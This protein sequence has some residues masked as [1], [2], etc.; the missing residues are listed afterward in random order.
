MAK[1]MPRVSGAQTGGKRG[2]GVPTNT[3]GGA[4]ERR[5]MLFLG[6]FMVAAAFTID[7]V[8]LVVTAGLVWI[9]IVGAIASFVIDMGISVMATCL[10]A[11][12]F[13]YKDV[14]F[15]GRIGSVA[16]VIGEAVPFFNNFPGWTIGV[17]WTILMSWREDRQAK[18]AIR[19]GEVSTP[20]NDNLPVV[21]NDN[22]PV[23]PRKSVDAIGGG[24]NNGGVVPLRKAA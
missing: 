24:R 10:F 22:G 13:Y 8:Q 7:I 3:G 12:W 9:P 18:K 15:L 1:I 19:R 4:G 14:R 20:A 2:G 23:V 11:L 5:I 21:V 16:A 6:G 17:G